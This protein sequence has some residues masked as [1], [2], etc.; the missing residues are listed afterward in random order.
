MTNTKSRSGPGIARVFWFGERDLYEQMENPFETESWRVELIYGG[1]GPEDG[2]DAETL[3][4][5]PEAEEG[6]G[7]EAPG[8][9]GPGGGLWAPILRVFAG[10][11]A[12][13]AYIAGQ[14]AEEGDYPVLLILPSMDISSDDFQILEPRIQEQG[15]DFCLSGNPRLIRSRIGSCI[16]RNSRIRRY[17][18]AAEIRASRMSRLL[19][20]LPDIV[21]QLDEEGRILEISQSVE[22]LGYQAEELIGCSFTK[23]ME[24][25]EADMVMRR[26]ILYSFAGR[27]TGDAYSPGLVDE[28]RGPHRKTQNLEV[29]LKVHPDHPRSQY[30]SHIIGSLT[31]YGETAFS[32]GDFP[33]GGG[34]LCRRTVGIIRD[35]TERRESRRRLQMLFQ[36]MD[37]TPE[38]AAM[39]DEDG[40]IEYAN[41]AFFRRFSL[42]P[43]QLLPDPESQGDGLGREAGGEADGV[44]GGVVRVGFFAALRNALLARGKQ[45]QEIL[46]AAGAEEEAGDSWFRVESSPIT[47]SENRKISTLF[48]ITD[49]TR[50]K[51]MEQ[52]RVAELAVKDRLL[53]EIHHRVKNNLQV[54]SS[55][56]HLQEHLLRDPEDV[57]LLRES[58]ARIRSMALVHDHLNQTESKQDIPLEAF[59]GSLFSHLQ[60]I[61]QPRDCPVPRLRMKAEGKKVSLSRITPLALLL[62]E[63]LSNSFKY[64]FPPGGE[65]AGREPEITVSLDAAGDGGKDGILV[66]GDNGVGMEA[67]GPGP[68]P[69]EERE[70]A[71]RLS[72]GRQLIEELA[73]QMGE[74]I[75]LLEDRPGTVYQLTLSNYP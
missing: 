22:N 36:G 55:F 2:G 28:R 42:A 20:A 74:S 53:D 61:Y 72:L 33:D 66:V 38:M 71:P 9:E 34:Q 18:Q 64:A 19:D 1:D 47:D 68:S 75:V 3:L 16:Q 45:E 49:I 73:D 65:W 7:E 13:E 15:A 40:L 62:T 69:E 57:G 6:P 56:L 50:E 27:I 11:G 58:Q 67:S 24:P 48:L 17:R 60:D 41:P 14:F 8:E 12:G 29:R 4:E 70:G 39:A 51:Q 10:K 46:L 5:F 32:Q 21:Y 44:P 63:I 43:G 52:Q 23:L 35:I 25:E 37:Q 31:A 59:V 26:S 30:Q 54:V